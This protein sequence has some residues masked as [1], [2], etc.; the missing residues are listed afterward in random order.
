MEKL[1]WPD[2]IV[3][4]GGASKKLHKFLP[5]IKTTAPVVPASFL[6]QAG[7]VGAALFAEEEVQLRR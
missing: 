1:F 3:L 5:L 2:L 7:I 4:G 6:N